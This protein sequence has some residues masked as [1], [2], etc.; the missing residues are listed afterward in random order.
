MKMS[1]LSAEK[2]GFRVAGFW[3]YRAMDFRDTWLE[4][5]R[6]KGGRQ[7]EN[8]LPVRKLR[9]DSNGSRRVFQRY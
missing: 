7:C 6:S 9:T 3:L 8:G 2:S 5:K 1:K 4:A